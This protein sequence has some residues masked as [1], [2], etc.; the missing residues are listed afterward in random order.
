MGGEAGVD[1]GAGLGGRQVPWEP[2][3]SM[4]SWTMTLGK[5]LQP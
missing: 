2:G 5:D 3:E 4:S 1:S